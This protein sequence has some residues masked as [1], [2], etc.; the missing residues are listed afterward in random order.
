[1]GE[2]E[3]HG[4]ERPRRPRTL[5]FRVAS[6]SIALGGQGG[7]IWPD[8]DGRSMSSKGRNGD[9]GRRWCRNDENDD[10]R[11]DFVWRRHLF[12]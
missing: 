1:M 12:D 4:A 10:G 8:R 2:W 5:R 3:G 11:H 6:S 9:M 7:A